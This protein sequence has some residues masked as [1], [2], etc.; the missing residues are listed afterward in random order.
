MAEI[1]TSSYTIRYATSADVPV[2]LQ[3]I[4]ELASYEKA[5]HEVL[6]TE[7]SLRATLSF[8]EAS[9]PG[10]FTRG[11]AK[12]LLILP[13][14]TSSTSTSSE[15]VASSSTNNAGA[16]AAAED[17]VEDKVE[18]AGMALFFH[19]Y[20]TW[21]SAPGI[22][23]EDLFVRPAY[24]GTGFGGAL[25]QALA[26]E[27]VSLGCKR[28]DWSVLKWNEPSIKFYEGGN[29]GAKRMDEWMGMRVD[30]ERLED[31]ARKGLGEA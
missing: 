10:G 6:A 5:L 25:I 1:N 26:R 7:Q 31:L 4:Q 23:L 12:T 15:G 27:C 20:S 11:Y 24:R 9:A 28:L 14:N 2:I 29:I 13:N 17:K 21:T 19:N 16:T 8:P 18:V 3:L 22:Y 30:G